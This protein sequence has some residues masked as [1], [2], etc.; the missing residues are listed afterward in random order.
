MTAKQ[1]ENATKMKHKKNIII[2]SIKESFSL[3]KKHKKIVLNLLIIQVFFVGIMIFLQTF[4]QMQAFD[5]AQEVMDYL[6]AQ[7]L[8]DL[9]VAKNIATGQ[10]LLGDDPLV[11]YRGMMEVRRIMIHLI[12]YSVLAY[13][14]L[15]SISWAL[16]DQ[17]I[18][19]KI[20]KNVW[21]YS[22]KFMP[23]AFGLILLA[24]VLTYSGFRGIMASVLLEAEGSAWSYVYIFAAIL[25]IYLMFVSFAMISK[26]RY[27]VLL[28]ESFDIAWRKS[29]IIVLTG[30]MN[31]AVILLVTLLVHLLSTMN[32]ALLSLALI[33]L[34]FSFV[35][36]RIFFVLVV[37]NLK[38]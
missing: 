37:D 38:N 21:K 34:I 30:V 32:M 11:I 10:S 9:T 17:L 3:I 20:I 29:H 22:L 28:K 25:L 36:A 13:L 2:G 12:A 15:G 23:V 7:D 4:Y 18:N 1:L 26:A 5:A 16:T 27:K 14:I 33:V 6:G 35:W 19:K 8:S 24:I 31:V